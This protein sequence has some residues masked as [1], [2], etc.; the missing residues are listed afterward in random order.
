MDKGF[1]DYVIQN[2]NINSN[3]LTDVK[4]LEQ[5]YFYGFQTVVLNVVAGDKY[6]ISCTKTSDIYAGAA[7]WSDSSYIR[8][9]INESAYDV[10]ITIPDGATRLIVNG[11]L[12]TIPIEVK[13]YEVTLD[14]NAFWE[15]YDNI[16]QSISKI[17][18]ALMSVT[19]HLGVYKETS[20]EVGVYMHNYAANTDLKCTI[21]KKTGN[22]LPDIEG[23]SKCQNDSD[24]VLK[25]SGTQK[26]DLINSGT[27]FLSPSTIYATSNLNGDFPDMTSGKLTG[28]WHMYNS[29][30]SGNYTATARNISY[31]VFCDGKEV[32]DGESVRGSEVII[33]IVNRLQASNTEKSDGTGREVCEQT[34]RIIFREGFKCIVEGSI[35]ALEQ[36]HIATFYGVSAMLMAGKPFRWIGCRANRQPQTP[37]TE[38]NRC[39][40]K[41][42]NGIEQV[43]DTDTFV[44]GID[45]TY[46]LGTMYANSW[47]HSNVTGSGK[48]YAVFIAQN[49]AGDDSSRLALNANDVVF[50]RGF[51]DW[52]PNI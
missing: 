40:D 51:Y 36:I 18:T 39:G 8:T 49:A 33:E 31:K 25:D 6:K 29:A 52:H 27:D 44:M 30:V 35:K 17:D 9:V 1:K 37:K 10:E 41:F 43:G 42:C 16:K 11:R 4:T 23:W 12:T 5:K 48:S 45:S 24:I 21:R 26:T 14:E 50:W 34:F 28:G 3:Y 15:D 47:I 2:I 38:A 22:N 20:G 19:P 7:I 32:I 46:D 13:K